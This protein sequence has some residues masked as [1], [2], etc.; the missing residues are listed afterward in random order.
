MFAEFSLVF[1]AVQSAREKLVFL[2]PLH[3]VAKKS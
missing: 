3:S 1:D 2:D